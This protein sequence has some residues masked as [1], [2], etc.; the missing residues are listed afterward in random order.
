[1]KSM[2]LHVVSQMHIGG[3]EKGIKN[4]VTQLTG[5][6]HVI[7]VLETLD[8]KW[9]ATLPNTVMVI[10]L[11]RKPGP[12]F[13]SYLKIIYWI[14]TLQPD[15]IHTRNLSTLECQLLAKYCRV[16]ACIHS[17]HGRDSSDLFGLCKKRQRWRKLFRPFVDRY[18]TVSEE[19]S[20]YLQEKI[21]I[22]AK[23]I[24]VI[25]NG[26]ELP[27]NYQPLKTGN[28]LRIGMVMRLVDNKQPLHCLEALAQLKQLPIQ[29]DIV[30]SGP[31]MSKVKQA[32]IDLSL[33]AQVNLLDKQYHLQEFYQ[34][35]HLVVLP[36]QFEGCSNVVLEAMAAGLVVIASD[37]PGNQA[38]IRSGEN[39]L[40]YPFGKVDA[41]KQCLISCLL[42]EGT[43]T[44]LGNAAY[45]TIEK[46]FTLS[47]MLKTY[48]RC[49]KELLCAV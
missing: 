18:F 40:L 39:G 44:L 31:E 46:N 23:K 36:S 15:L 9:V 33:S 5:F 8:L 37:I 38:I 22:A 25:P 3:L 28:P 49:Y 47:V 21:K 41:L 45:K 20:R 11:N 24:T 48:E 10:V 16:R 27:L 30:G 13:R 34:H 29:C 2:I 14:K 6:Q 7:L 4:I 1:M 35:W 26:V 42:S 32:I 12:L 19:L 43:R 17:E